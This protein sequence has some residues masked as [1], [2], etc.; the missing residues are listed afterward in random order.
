MT[1]LE[2]LAQIGNFRLRRNR[3]FFSE[4]GDFAA[5][6]TRAGFAVGIVRGVKVYHAAGVIANEEYGYMDLCIEK[7]SHDPEYSDHLSASVAHSQG[8]SDAARHL[9]INAEGPRE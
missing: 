8:S 2:V 7:Y 9:W 4:D 3:I 6:C 1:S 5:R